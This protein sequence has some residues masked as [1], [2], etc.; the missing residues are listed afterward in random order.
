MF[1]YIAELISL[2]IFTIGLAGVMVSNVGIKML[3]SIELMLNASIF[4][5]VAA[6]MSSGSVTPLIMALFAIAIGAAE[7]VVGISLLVSIY[8]KY[9]KIT[10]SLLKEIRW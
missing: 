5:L 3:I 1:L 10:I 8:K 4:S 9:G 2:L 7:S 6:G